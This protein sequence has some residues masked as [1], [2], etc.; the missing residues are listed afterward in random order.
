MN[1]Q[2]R[3]DH[4][5]VLTQHYSMQWI[6]LFGRKLKNLDSIKW[7]LKWKN[8][9]K[10][11]MREWSFAL[12]KYQFSRQK[13]D[14]NSAQN[15]TLRV[16]YKNMFWLSKVGLCE[17]QPSFGSPSK[18]ERRFRELQRGKCFRSF[19]QGRP[20]LDS[21]YFLTASPHF[22]NV[23]PKVPDNM[24]SKSPR[25]GKKSTECKF[26]TICEQDFTKIIWKKQERRFKQLIKKWIF[27]YKKNKI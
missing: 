22:T 15:A 14:W 8:W 21:V 27:N 12:L 18:T 7:R 19:D 20:L 10:W 2:T 17:L 16:S 1:W 9:G 26:L 25:K 11:L 3:F 6:Q 5:M 4:G 13:N 23:W 24:N